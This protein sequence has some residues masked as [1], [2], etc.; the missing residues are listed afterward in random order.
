MALCGTLNFFVGSH[1]IIDS[2]MIKK[3]FVGVGEALEEVCHVGGR[4]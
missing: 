1:K 3:W 2:E 4:L